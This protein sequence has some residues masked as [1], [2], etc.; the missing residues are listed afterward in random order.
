[1]STFERDQTDGGVG[2]ER[3]RARER[4]Q[5]RR[6]FGAHLVSYL[7]VNTFLIMVWAVNGAGH[8]RPIWVIGGWGVGLVLHAWGTFLRRPV[9]GQMST[10]SSPGRAGSGQ[11][12][13]AE[14]RLKAAVTAV[15]IGASR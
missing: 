1:M 6:D 15:S 10:R 7:V 13:R 3:Q 11:P 5:A 2:T 14:P 9:T 4:V 12:G 8:F